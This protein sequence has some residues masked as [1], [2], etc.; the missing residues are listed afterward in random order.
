MEGSRL[1]LETMT[2]WNL[3]SQVAVDRSGNL[4]SLV[5]P[6]NICVDSSPNVPGT[7]GSEDTLKPKQT[8]HLIHYPN[9]IC[10]R[11]KG[12]TINKYTRKPGINWGCARLTRIQN[13]GQPGLLS[14]QVTHVGSLRA[15]KD[16]VKV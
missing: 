3:S 9:H 6:F 12:E 14:V 4:H 13:W 5:H 16:H 7:L 2:N 10:L 11:V 1:A 8:Y 15:G